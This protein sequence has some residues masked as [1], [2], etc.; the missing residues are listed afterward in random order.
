MD[1]DDD[2]DDDDDKCGAVCGMRIGRGNGSTR[3]ENLPLWCL[4]VYQKSHMIK[5]GIEPRPLL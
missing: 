1:D 3:R 2:D 5:P 4:F